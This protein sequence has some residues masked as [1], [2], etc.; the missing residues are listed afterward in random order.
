MAK[1]THNRHICRECGCDLAPLGLRKGAVFCT[2]VHR[3][4]WNNRRM[5]R[6]A[7]L[8][9]L[10]MADNY[11]RDLRGEHKLLGLAHSL[12]RAYRDSDKHLRNG[13]KS[14]DAKEAIDRVP[15]AFGAEGDKR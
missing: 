13:R 2:P 1:I 4:A 14:W 15:L 3:K 8:Y 10:L 6:G 9:D 11:E 5:V 7:E 12:M